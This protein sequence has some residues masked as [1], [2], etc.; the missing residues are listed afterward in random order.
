MF[1][2]HRNCSVPAVPAVTRRPCR[3]ITRLV[4]APIA[5]MAGLPAVGCAEVETVSTP[6]VAPVW[7]PP[8]TQSNVAPAGTDQATLM[9]PAAAPS[10]WP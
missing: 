7:I 4:P 8:L 5:P 1:C 2:A 6:V 10:S 3:G 9:S